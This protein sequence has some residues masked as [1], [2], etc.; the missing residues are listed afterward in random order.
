VPLINED[1]LKFDIQVD[2][3]KGITSVRQFDREFVRSIQDVRR[4]MKALDKAQKGYFNEARFAWRE[5]QEEVE[6]TSA[7]MAQ[8]D[9]DSALAEKSIAAITRS[10]SAWEAGTKTL[11]QKQ[12][13][14][15][16][17]YLAQ[18]KERVADTKKAKGIIEDLGKE[19]VVIKMSAAA[20]AMKESL[21]KVAAPLTRL[22]SKDISGAFEEGG[23]LAAAAVSRSAL[24]LGRAMKSKGSSLSQ[25]GAGLATKGAAAGPG[26]KGKGLEMLGGAMKGIGGMMAKA[27]P[28][29]Q[30]L[31]QLGPILSMTAGALVSVVKLIVDAEAKAK[32][33]QKELLASA[34]TGEF[35]T[36]NAQNAN[37]AYMDLAQTVT[38]LRD[39]AFNLKQNLAWGTTSK[40]HLAFRN[41]LTQEG[42]SIAR[43]ADEFER[44][45]KEGKFTGDAVEYYGSQTAVAVA[46]A[47]NFGVA[48]NEITSFQTHMMVE[49]GSSFSDVQHEF[50]NMATAAGGSGMAMNKF[51]A[52]MRGVSSDLS[53]YNMRMEDAVG[54]LNKLGKVMSPQ[55]A[56]KF[57]GTLMQGFKNM[58]RLDR[59]RMTLLAGE[60]KTRQVFE[61]D[62]KRR[63]TALAEKL[64]SQAKIPLDAAQKA[65]DAYGKGQKTEFNNLVKGLEGGGALKEAA[66]ELKIDRKM[67]KKGVFGLSQATGNLGVTGQIDM[68]KAA[69][70]RFAKPGAKLSDMAGE[71]GPEMMAENLGIGREQLN[72]T[73]KLEEA[74]DEAREEMRATGSFTKEQLE[75]DDEVLKYAGITR[76]EAKQ[77]AWSQLDYAKQQSSLTSSLLD[78]LDV[79]IDFL[80]NQFY[81]VII[82][83]WDTILDIPGLGGAEKKMQVAAMRSK[84]KD[85]IDAVTAAGG[86][87]WKAKG[88]I[89][90]SA[91]GKRLM[92][93]LAG[94]GE[95]PGKRSRLEE[96]EKSLSDTSGLYGKLRSSGKT[97][98]EANAE[99]K[100]LQE[101]RG[102]LKQ[103]IATTE[104]RTTDAFKAV[105][106][107]WK[108]MGPNEG[109]DK[110]WD[111]INMTN[112][113]QTSPSAGGNMVLTEKYLKEGMNLS[114]AME[115]A[116]FTPEEMGQIM[117]KAVWAMAPQQVAGAAGIYGR[118]AS[119]AEP[120][121]PGAPGAP[122]APP[123]PGQPTPAAAAPGAVPGVTTPAPT[124]PAAAPA[125]TTAPTGPSADVAKPIQ[126]TA[127][128]TTTLA[129]TSANMLS[130][131]EAMLDALRQQ[132]IKIDKPFLKTNLGKQ[133]EDSTYDA[134]SKALFEYW[135]Y[136]GDDAK[137]KSW[138]KYAAEQGATDLSATSMRTVALDW[139]S[140]TEEGKGLAAHAG[141]GIVT[142]I[143]GGVAMTKPLTAA[144]GEGLLSVGPHEAI[145]PLNKLGPGAAAPT[146]GGGK[147]S[148]AV[149]VNVNGVNDNDFQRGLKTAVTN[150]IYEYE[151]R[152]RVT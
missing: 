63:E 104:A 27:G 129:A 65:V 37:M 35:L 56:Q 74:M 136:S 73:I 115:R 29:M 121:A 116:G 108:A 84:N 50:S 68:M 110:L 96:V 144:P 23:K 114:D 48:L 26:I 76:E 124:A 117:S 113:R 135:L 119:G 49:L 45:K 9:K 111:A 66:I 107:Q 54:L 67:S 6:A 5:V 142:G 61:K 147:S 18:L 72:N 112:L 149:D 34:S 46:Y 93:G 80:M 97:D 130:T 21:S 77:A 81:N 31:A 53:L 92:G 33:F 94:A 105:D 150:Y 126:T 88:N 132:G 146:G 87:V 58:G 101:E 85:V 139:A 2:P 28:M 89:I 20:D 55:N 41:V 38:D 100:A 102:R 127:E 62:A 1:I 70:G 109:M 90:E 4:N 17:K 75:N 95:V 148:L 79:I 22:M 64:A 120:T 143:A 141:G 14:Q 42:V 122:G 57:M 151:R 19:T 152:K 134:M 106:A 82:G 131:N 78:K 71:L 52:I 10:L 8:C 91:I 24:S 83:I 125:P 13:D 44:A 118:T 16:R 103:E 25:L 98:E 99:I 145:L 43:M 123:V 137:V 47:R 69:L 60:G 51:F 140:K 36:K 40:D 39:S 30:T 32:E 15:H 7:A 133:I 86:D 11:S 128:S 138:L 3:K 59:L 12:V